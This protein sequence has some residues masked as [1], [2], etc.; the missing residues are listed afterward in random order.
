MTGLPHPAD[1]DMVVHGH[2]KIQT[3]ITT[4][5]SENVTSNHLRK[6]T[7][8]FFN[9]RKVSRLLDS[10]FGNSPFLTWCIHTEPLFLVKLFNDGPEKTCKKVIAN[11]TKA[12]KNYNKFTK[13]EKVSEDLRIAK[14]RIALTIAIADISNFWGLKQVV[15]SISKFADAALCVATNFLTKLLFPENYLLNDSKENTINTSGII[16]IGMGKLG[17]QELNY[18]SDIDIIVLF[19]P[20]K[21]QTKEPDKIQQKLVRFTRDLVKLMEER[22]ANGYVFRTDLRLRPDP[23]ATAI[24]L[25]TQAAEV[26]YESIGQN[27]ERA[28]MIK[29][30]PIA[31]DISEGKK[32]LK[33]LE[34]F[35]WR[36]NLDFA[37]IQDIHSM[38]ERMSDQIKDPF[39]TLKGYDIK[40]GHGGIREIEFYVQA[41]QL[42]WGGRQPKIRSS[43]TEAALNSLAAFKLCSKKTSKELQ[44]CYKFLRC[45]EH[46]IQMVHDKQS[47]SLPEDSD[48]FEKFS[49]FFGYENSINFSTEL[50]RVIKL[51][52]HHYLQLFKNSSPLP[53]NHEN[54]TT[55]IFSRPSS[56]P[57]TLKDMKDIG[58]QNPEIIDA[59][60]RKWYLGRY[61]SMR[62]ERARMILTGL[63]PIL[64]NSI[65]K[66]LE[67]EKTFIL[68]DEFLSRL[69]AGVQLF[70]MFEAHPQLLNL[71]L[72]ILGKAPRLAQHLINLPS[73]LDFVLTPGFFDPLPSQ[74]KMCSQ[75]TSLLKYSE[76]HEDILNIS[77]QWANDLKFQVGVQQLQN[78]LN[79]KKVAQSLTNIAD[80]LLKCLFPIIKR[81]Y[82]AK[83]GIIPGASVAIL[84]LGK[85]GSKEMTP[86]S[87]L[88]VVF[89][90]STPNQNNK[91]NGVNTLHAAK[92]FSRFCQS[93][94][95]TIS[96]T[97]PYGKLYEVDMRLRPLGNSG[98]IAIT[99][100]SFKKYQQQL[101]WTW[102]HMALTQARPI[103]GDP[104]F[105]KEITKCIRSILI[106]ERDATKV[107][108][109]VLEM[110][111]RI[112][113]THSGDHD[114]S[115]K[116]RKGG[117]ID[118]EFITQYLVLT[119]A[120]KHTKLLNIGT[121]PTLK[122]LKK[123][124]LISQKDGE[125]L[126]KS[127][128][129]WLS[130]WSILSLT[131][132]KKLTNSKI[133]EIPENLKGNLAK[134]GKVPSF[135]ALEY[136]MTT[137][138]SQVS[139][140]YKKLIKPY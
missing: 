108:K 120:H 104:D 17:A 56:D 82:A 52:N 36:K 53:A 14:R 119:H 35:I 100:K 28:A 89:I 99:Y 37:A 118:I 123:I 49:T 66:T 122:I 51:A 26:Y 8:S 67:P 73:T 78:L 44:S 30:R 57:Q 124:N 115:L 114:W 103:T 11:I 34:P 76:Y 93:Y 131:I 6:T 117:I 92:Y 29:S 10:I 137:T 133:I 58:F 95:N 40:L 105:Q 102:E 86:S 33:Q 71:V 77:R 12:S 20:E 135:K 32:F 91:S 128:E 39:Q 94:I 2:E 1:K 125:T 46:R 98:P 3:I 101:A 42:I 113:K 132:A 107:A 65:A 24:A 23:G 59:L 4:L 127:Y 136:K 13:P 110:R 41:L 61:R 88:D 109:D 84:A 97:T 74:N 79:A 31:G 50:R 72:E 90:Y 45:L 7:I 55:L 139:K 83:Y 63:I 60:I 15:Q 48:A 140:I 68:F 106:Q 112:R 22:T 75:L 38:K 96:A 138:S 126:I 80:T 85:L 18:S 69:P 19:N 134:I 129:L 62:S 9:K 5:L 130:L 27:W 25:S 87:D 81:Q 70:S 116:H 21:I 64:L 54:S 47:H 121:L 111:T 43:K 16:I